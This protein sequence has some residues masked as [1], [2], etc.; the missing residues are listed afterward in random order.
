MTEVAGTAAFVTGGARGIG[1]GI[2]SKLLDAGARVAIAD[3]S[4][5]NLRRALESFSGRD[6]IGVTLDV[7]DR[8]AFAAAADE[9]EA[10]LGPISIV[11]NNAGV[12]LFAPID[13]CS[14]DDWDWVLGVNLHGVI[15][16]CQTFVP[17]LKARGRGG[18]IVNTASM[19]AFLAGPNGGIYTA[20]KFA[21][22]GLTESL[23]WSLAP[24]DIGVSCLCPGRVRS[25]TYESGLS[26]AGDGG[27]EMTD[28]DRE[29]LDRLAQLHDAGM[30]PEEVAGQVIAGIS[31]NR[32]YIF[33]DGEFRDELKECFDEILSALPEQRPS[34][35]CRSALHGGRPR[36]GGEE[37]R[38]PGS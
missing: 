6:V 1:L 36:T 21:V 30:D 13:D 18:H 31:A 15:N 23:R 28:A 9:A 12:N 33:P 3:I 17:R 22:R 38:S 20:S 7:A 2:V 19:A 32:L 16:G 24:H 37:E 35:G 4:P 8:A 25:A 26:R 34:A 10:Q 27:R 11:C 14:Y 5:D 29:L